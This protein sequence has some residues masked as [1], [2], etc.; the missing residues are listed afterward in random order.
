MFVERRWGQGTN[1]ADK[2]T[3]A[4]QVIDPAR[5][6]LD[7]AQIPVAAMTSFE[8]LS[9]PVKRPQ[10]AQHES[11]VNWETIRRSALTARKQSTVWPSGSAGRLVDIAKDAL[12]SCSL[13]AVVQAF[14]KKSASDSDSSK[15]CN[16]G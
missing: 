9:Y 8:R 15:A 3:T 6:G 13:E 11:M 16:S 4:G 2:A 5:L 10:R 7:S 12:V 1:P 14:L